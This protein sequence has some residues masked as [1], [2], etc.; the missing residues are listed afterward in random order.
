[1]CLL[2]SHK[3]DLEHKITPAHRH[4]QRARAMSQLTCMVTWCQ[5]FNRE[6]AREIDAGEVCFLVV[7]VGKGVCCDVVWCGGG[8][9]QKLCAPRK[10]RIHGY[11]LSTNARVFSRNYLQNSEIGS[12]PGSLCGRIPTIV[13]G[14]DRWWDLP[15]G[16]A[17]R[18]LSIL[19]SRRRC[20][21]SAR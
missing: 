10:S 18:T 1:M 20:S 21:V 17:W 8:L 13:V 19:I 14:G 11:G 16:L 7:G 9:N 6:L 12:V 5:K 15:N 2:S 4:R 3:F